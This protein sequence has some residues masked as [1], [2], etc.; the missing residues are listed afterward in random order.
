MAKKTPSRVH[1][2][3]VIDF[4]QK[5]RHKEAPKNY[6]V[7][8]FVRKMRRGYEKTNWNKFCV[9][10]LMFEVAHA[11][12]SHSNASF[13]AGGNYFV[14]ADGATGLN[15]KFCPH[16]AGGFDAVGKREEGL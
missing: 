13:V 5:S 10:I 3:K 15:D 14:V 9:Y 12:E 1:S 7:S 6:F 8:P 11:G 16:F 4:I 2:E